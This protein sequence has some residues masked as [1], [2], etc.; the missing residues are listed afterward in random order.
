LGDTLSSQNVSKTYG[1]LNIPPS[2]TGGFSVGR[3]TRWSLGTEFSYQDWSSFRDVSKVSQ[4]LTQAWRLG[5]GGE[6][7][8][9]PMAA[10]GVVKRTTYRLGYSAELCPF[11]VN[12]KQVKD[13]GITFGFSVPTG[14]SSLDMAVKFGKR[15]NVSDN[16]L[17]QN[18]FKISFGVTFNDQWFIRRKFD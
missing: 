16:L 15:G 6:F 13:N 8:P 2:L 9:D 18:Y 10:Q 7:T 12:G 1:S 5:F 11:L 4:N 17:E 3:G 14:R